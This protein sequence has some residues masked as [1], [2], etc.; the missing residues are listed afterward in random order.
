MNLSIATSYPLL[1]APTGE[2]QI[3]HRHQAN[4]LR[5]P[6]SQA[7]GIW[8]QPDEGCKAADLDSPESSLPTGTDIRW[9][10]VDRIGREIADGTYDTPEK[11]Q[12]A[13]E[14]MLEELE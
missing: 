6:I 14:R 2:T 7:R 9:E 3:M 13:L 5:G 1:S 11:L 4:C 12:Q 8:S 10:L